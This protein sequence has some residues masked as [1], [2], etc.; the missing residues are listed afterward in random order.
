MAASTV[1]L[2][3]FKLNHQP[4][5]LHGCSKSSNQTLLKFN[6]SPLKPF[7]ISSRSGS[8]RFR[9]LPETINVKLEDHGVMALCVTLPKRKWRPRL[10]RLTDLSLRVGRFE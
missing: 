4:N 2:S 6:F 3:C 1:P 7:L 5:L 10:N 9:V 8:R